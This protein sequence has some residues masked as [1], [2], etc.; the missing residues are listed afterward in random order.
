MLQAAE[1]VTILSQL[2][3]SA[4]QQYIGGLPRLGV[5]L[6]MEAP[7]AIVVRFITKFTTLSVAVLPLPGVVSKCFDRFPDVHLATFQAQEERD[8][9]MLDSQKVL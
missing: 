1:I 4:A 2:A 3:I 8:A 7:Y 6:R 9:L 5:Y